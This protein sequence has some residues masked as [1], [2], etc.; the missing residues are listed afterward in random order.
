MRKAAT[1]KQP[2]RLTAHHILPLEGHTRALRRTPFPIRPRYRLQSGGERRRWLAW[3]CWWVV[4]GQEAG[5][6][7]LGGF[8]R[9]TAVCWVGSRGEEVGGVWWFTPG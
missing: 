5:A 2:A 1:G 9:D 7:G 6:A 4:A 8:S 3:V